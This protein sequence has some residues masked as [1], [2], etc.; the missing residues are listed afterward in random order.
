M[1]ATLGGGGHAALICDA[2]APGGVLVGIDRDLEAIEAAR[3]RL[4]PAGVKVILVH[5]NYAALETILA[6]LGLPA[7]DGVLFDLGLSSPQVDRAERGFSYQ[8]DAPLDMRMDRRQA[9]TAR[10]LVNEAPEDDLAGI[11]MR[12]GEERWARRIASFIVQRRRRRS[13]ETTGELVEI[14]KAAIPAKA[15][16]HGPHPA[17]RTFQALRIAVNDELGSLEAGLRG[18]IRALAPGGRLAA[19][20]FHSLEDR[21]IKE[22]F[23][24]AAEDAAH[25]AGGWIEL[26]TKKPVRPGAAEVSRNPR[27]RSAKLRALKVC[28]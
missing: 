24:K 25:P 28:E 21:L 9:L 18:G 2:I 8:H 23:R 20:S 27:A 16:R 14:I 5:E 26:L 10:Q 15:R 19:I 22:E 1:D 3:G 7:V 11:I 4:Q 13:V 17:R 6:G 12:Y